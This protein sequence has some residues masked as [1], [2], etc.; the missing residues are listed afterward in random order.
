[1]KIVPIDS[2][3]EPVEILKATWENNTW[4]LVVSCHGDKHGLMLTPE[5][6]LAICDHP[7]DKVRGEE[8]MADL[9]GNARECLSV[10]QSQALVAERYLPY[11]DTP[12]SDLKNGSFSRNTQRDLGARSN[13]PRP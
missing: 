12:L 6:Q 10:R 3:G 1:M 13:S 5:K 2:S 7:T 4:N 11:C 9:A 8:A